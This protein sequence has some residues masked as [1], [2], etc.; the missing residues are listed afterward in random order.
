[1]KK[2]VIII[3]FAVGLILLLLSF[4]N[5]N[6]TLKNIFIGLG[7]NIFG[8]VVTVLFVQ[9]IIDKQD[10]INEKN[11][12]KD[13]IIRFSRFMTIMIR[14]YTA[15]FAQITI[16]I[17]KFPKDKTP[18]L[19]TEFD[20]EDMKDLHK[21]CLLMSE[22]WKSA[23]STFYKQEKK[24]KDYM[25]RMLENIGFKYYPE[26]QKTLTD[27]IENSEAYD[28]SS[29]IINNET[30]QRIIDTISNCFNDNQKEKWVEKFDSNDL[31]SNFMFNYVILYKLLKIEASLLIGYEREIE[32]IE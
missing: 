26:I 28:V 15:L 4:L 9:R 18:V 22:G 21:P 32:K 5:I 31:H 17:S 19:K 27:F 25:L 14:R 29:A 23:I 13:K 12:E 7:T 6:E 30:D 10:K 2:S 11:E 1:M 20:F 8:I 16:P 24:L 3:L